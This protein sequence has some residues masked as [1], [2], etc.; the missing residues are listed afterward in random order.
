MR[1]AG[2]AALIAA[3]FTVGIQ[4]AA[5]ADLPLRSRPSLVQAAHQGQQR[6]SNPIEKE[7]L[8]QEFLEWLKKK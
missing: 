7:V 5:A 3:G 6:N 1:S 2:I 8:F 4:A